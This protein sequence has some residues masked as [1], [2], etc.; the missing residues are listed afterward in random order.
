MEHG[1]SVAL[2]EAT[3]PLPAFGYTIGLW[4]S[5]GYPEIISFGLSPSSL[6]AILNNAGDLV[7]AGHSIALNEANWEIFNQGPALFREVHP[8]NIVDYFGYGRWF[9]DYREFPAIQLFWPD[10]AGKFPWEKG[11]AETGRKER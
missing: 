4:Q 9:N 2:F 8:D 6:G 11:N 3:S 10:T 7:K 1:W 5:Y